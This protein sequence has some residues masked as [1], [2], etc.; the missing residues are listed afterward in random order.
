[1]RKALILTGLISLAPLGAGEAQL[2]EDVRPLRQIDRALFELE[3]TI[4]RSC[5]PDLADK[6]EDAMT[7]LE[8]AGQELAKRPPDDQAAAGNLEGAIGDL[9]AAV[10]DKCFDP[11]TGIG[12]MDDL[13]AISRQLATRSLDAAFS[14]GG[15][16]DEIHQARNDLARGD[17]LRAS[18]RRGRLDAFKQAANKYKDA[19]SKAQSA[20]H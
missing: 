12:V 9:E 4:H 16:R 6:A 8:D 1:M 15:K 5:D 2:V 20:T 13:A 3:D 11:V 19:L 17:A 7:K 14:Y 18:G 10:K